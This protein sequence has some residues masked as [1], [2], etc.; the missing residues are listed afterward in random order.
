LNNK[1]KI[2]AAAE[3]IFVRDGFDGARTNAIAKEAGV[4]KAM[5]H[6]YFDDKGK[7]FE[8]VFK[9]KSSQFFPKISAYFLSD[10]SV[11]E[12]M[13]YFIETYMNLLIA[14]PKIPPFVI[15]TMNKYPGFIRVFPKGFLESMIT[16]LQVESDA[17]KIKKLDARQ[18]FMSVVG[19]CVF[20][21]IAKTVIGH[22]MNLKEGEFDDILEGRKEEVKSYVRAILQLP[23]IPPNS[24]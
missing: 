16:Y 8:Q 1:E 24:E 3:K 7:L 15:C 5:L 13:D 20:P 18:F 22:M 14:N 19:M 17:G 4:N 21:F 10:N 9:M 2:L 6:Y 12:K 11:Q 23:Y